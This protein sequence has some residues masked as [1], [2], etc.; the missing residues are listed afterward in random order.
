MLFT[1]K[2]IAISKDDENRVLNKSGIL[3]QRIKVIP[4]ANCAFRR[5]RLKGGGKLNMQAVLLRASNEAHSDHDKF[6]IFKDPDSKNAT[7]WS[8][9][10]KNIS[11]I[12]SLP[13]TLC[14]KP[15]SS[16]SR[17]VKCMSGLEG[18][19]WDN[20]VLVASRWWHDNPSVEEWTSFIRVA[21]LDFE[22][23]AF[24]RPAP[25]VVDYN[26]NLP[27]I[28]F[29]KYK[30]ED[31]VTPKRISEFAFIAALFV[32]SFTSTKYFHYS[33]K[34]SNIESQKTEISTS[35]TDVSI[36]NDRRN[37]LLIKA[38]LANDP[39]NDDNSISASTQ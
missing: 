34:L 24:K 27:L 23:D 32:L 22:A 28:S 5:Y 3:G 25:E 12:R 20:G 4:R 39:P 30:L 13:E 16:G 17:L 19:V 9:N 2:L 26:N 29:D 36:T 10:S 21:P 6:K 1:P 7:V 38:L 8:Y 33:T 11:R 37:S 14:L 15:H 18:Q 31:I 35:V